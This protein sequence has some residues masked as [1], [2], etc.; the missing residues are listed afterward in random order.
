VSYYISV[1]EK[2]MNIAELAVATGLSRRAV[3]FYVQRGLLRAPHGRGRGRHY[4]QEHV[5]ELRRIR[6]LQESGHSLEAIKRIQSG[7]AIAA[8]EPNYDRY[9]RARRRPAL[10]AALWTRL[11]I[12]DGVELHLDA[13][14][15]N[16]RAED[17]LA[18]QQ[19]IN[20]LIG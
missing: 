16:P 5:A 15:Y 4:D 20:K 11:M 17:L 2:R 14:K 9:G 18:I 10:A 12:A 3:R 8:P 13:T 6:E 7:E 19:A 1:D